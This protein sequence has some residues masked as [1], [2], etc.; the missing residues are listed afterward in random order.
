[1]FTMSTCIKNLIK[2][3]LWT[4]CKAAGDGHCLL[5]STQI[6]WRNQVSNSVPPTYDEI[7]TNI[8]LE[9]IQKPDYNSKHELVSDLKNYILLKH[10]NS[11]FGDI[12]PT[13]IS[14]CFNIELIII[15]ETCDNLVTITPSTNI[16]QASIVLYRTHDHYSGVY[17]GRTS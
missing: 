13:I 6:S 7:K 2:E 15:N 16:P 10:F 8:F 4:Q 5:Y 17:L 1:M 14:N 9:V 12:V 11:S 3:G